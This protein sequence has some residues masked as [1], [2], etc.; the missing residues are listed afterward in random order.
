MFNFL[1]RERPYILMLVFIAALNLSTLGRQGK[2][3]ERAHRENEDSIS[4]MTFGELGVTEEKIKDFL[5]SAKPRAKFFKYSMIAGALMLILALILNLLFIFTGKRP[6]ATKKA[7]IET[8]SW[9]VSDLIRAGIIIVFLSYLIGMSQSFA[10]RFFHIE[11]GLDLRM[12]LSTFFVDI[13]VAWIVFYFVIVK[14]GQRLKSLGLKLPYF[15]SNVLTGLTAYVLTLP[16]L[17]VILLLSMWLLN[18]LKY[19]PP[20]QPI[21][22]VFMRE[23]RSRVLFFLMIFVSFFG[24]IVEEIFFRGFLYGAVRKRIGVIAAAFLTGAVFSL[25]HTNI[26]GFLPIMTLGVL[27]AYLY[28]TTGSLVA[29]M[30]VHVAHNSIIVAFVFFIKQLL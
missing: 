10:L 29:S 20:P 12:M 8:V 13:A 18:L 27:L 15:L 2:S 30:T 6:G 7:Q 21:L 25:L 1:R 4:A 16:L 17:A 9:G 22:E 26:A 3:P 24:P 5:Q 11:L 19:T 28:E 23:D 14:H